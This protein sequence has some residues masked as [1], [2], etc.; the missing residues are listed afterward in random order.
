MFTFFL[1]GKIFRTKPSCK[2]VPSGLRGP[3][4]VSKELPKVSNVADQDKKDS[5]R[6]LKAFAYSDP[7]P[8]HI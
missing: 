5:D 3:L 4:K 1:C 6:A 8:I 2:P 7:D